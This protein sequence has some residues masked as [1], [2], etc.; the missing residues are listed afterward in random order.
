[1]LS[2]R[3]DGL[4]GATARASAEKVWPRSLAFDEGGRL[5][6]TRPCL[7]RPFS[8]GQEDVYQEIFVNEEIKDDEVLSRIEFSEKNTERDPYREVDLRARRLMTA[9]S[10]LQYGNAVKQVF[11][12]DPDLH[13]IY[14]FTAPATWHK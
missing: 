2:L 11:R 13:A 7:R 8:G 12:E 6:L 3:R 10:A 14:A 1:Q 5:A 9:N 4:A